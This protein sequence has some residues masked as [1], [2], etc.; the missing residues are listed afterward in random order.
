MDPAGAGPQQWVTDHVPI[1]RVAMQRMS[2]GSEL[3]KRA[4]ESFPI[5]QWLRTL[6]V[7]QES[8]VQSLAGEP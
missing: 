7:K 4:C 8:T 5:V 3:K 2:P 1:G 6:L